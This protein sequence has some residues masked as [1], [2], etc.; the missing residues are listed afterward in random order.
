MRFPLLTTAASVLI[1]S[2]C[3][4]DGPTGPQC[5]DLTGELTDTRGDTLLINS[6]LRYIDTEEGGGTAAASCEANVEVSYTLSLA[7]GT[8]IEDGSL[9]AFRIGDRNWLPAFEQ[10][11]IGMREG[12]TRRLI[13][14]P[15]I[16]YGAT[17]VRNQAGEV[18]IPANSTLIFDVE[19][20]DVR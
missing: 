3:L 7:D 6:G 1:L 14:S 4:D 9:P 15:A 18:I 8:H 13:L 17:P 19:L 16:G 20:I 2:A 12:G 5:V 11:I 10:G